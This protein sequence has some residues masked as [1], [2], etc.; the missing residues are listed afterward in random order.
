MTLLA[1]GV[2][3]GALFVANSVGTADSSAASANTAA[4]APAAPQA[5]AAQP[6]AGPAPAGS[7][8]EI[9]LSQVPVAGADADAD[10]DAGAD[11]ADADPADAPAAAEAE[12]L[13]DNVYAGRTEDRMTV[14]IAIKDGEAVAYVCDG[15]A[16]E[17]WLSG[18]AT[19][20]GLDLV[21]RSGDVTMTGTLDGST[22]SGTVTIDG[23]DV[24]YVASET[25]VARAITDGRD[26][27]GEV[28]EKIGL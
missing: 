7:A 5:P 17:L 23:D 6:V 19:T 15:G 11:E 28:A 8:T 2:L 9:D 13:D 27:V 21:D 10:A 3:G 24:D 20:D 26:D 22:F 25:T 4:A 14:A 12:A 1:V 16:V 18:P